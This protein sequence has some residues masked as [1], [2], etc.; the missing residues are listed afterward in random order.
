MVV[1]N[2][3]PSCRIHDFEGEGCR[4]CGFGFDGQNSVA[5]WLVVAALNRWQETIDV[6]GRSLR[7]D[8]TKSEVIDVPTCCS[9]V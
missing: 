7:Q 2:G 3:L 6:H 1:H 4:G 8:V 9:T 5:I